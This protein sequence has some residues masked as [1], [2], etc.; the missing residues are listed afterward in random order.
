MTDTITGAARYVT[1]PTP[2]TAIRWC[3]ED[4]CEQVFALLGWEHGDDEAEHTFIEVPGLDNQQE[5][6]PGD[7][8][9]R[10]PD[11]TFK[12]FTDAEFHAEFEAAGDA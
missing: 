6:E 5:A 8:I 10:Y 9:V 4:N 7:W 12:K 3:G 1:K 11:D 2:V